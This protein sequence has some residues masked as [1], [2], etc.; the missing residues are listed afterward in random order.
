MLLEGGANINHQTEVRYRRVWEVELTHNSAPNIGYTTPTRPFG[1][2]ITKRYCVTSLYH[3]SHRDQKRT[4]CR[5]IPGR[6]HVVYELL[7]MVYDH[8]SWAAAHTPTMHVALRVRNYS[9][10]ST[11]DLYMASKVQ[12]HILAQDMK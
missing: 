3:R 12:V 9:A 1:V 6:Q 7:H 5:V 2:S 11:F 8:S 10:C 4:A